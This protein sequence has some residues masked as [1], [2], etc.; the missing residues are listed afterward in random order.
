[1]QFMLSDDPAFVLVQKNGREVAK[2]PLTLATASYVLLTEPP[3][4]E[5]GLVMFSLSVP[6]G[7]EKSMVACI[8]KKPQKKRARPPVWPSW[9][10]NPV[11]TFKENLPLNEWISLPTPGVDCA[12]ILKQC[13]DQRTRKE[14][15]VNHQINDRCKEIKEQ[16][17]DEEYTQSL[18]YYITLRVKLAYLLLNQ[19]GIAKRLEQ[20]KQCQAVTR[21]AIT[22]C[23]DA[24]A[25]EWEMPTCIVTPE[26]NNDPNALVC[27]QVADYELDELD[28]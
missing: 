21:A 2:T 13:S 22:S 24:Y 28:E 26:E 15:E 10:P 20:V 9:N 18:G 12:N 17:T 11:P 1:M 25:Q 16:G 23:N 19:D 27:P 4:T 14:V 7:S 6:E 8:R 5:G 3:K